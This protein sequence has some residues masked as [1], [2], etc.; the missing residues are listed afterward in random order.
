MSGA[1]GSRRRPVGISGELGEALTAP[2]AGEHVDE[3]VLGAE[4]VP[5]P[6]VSGRD[7][8]TVP[9]VVL[10]GSR[11]RRGRLTGLRWRRWRCRDVVFEGCD[12]SGV[13]VEGGA[14]ERVEFRDCRMSGVVLAG[15]KLTDVL[16]SGCK[17]DLANLR[18]VEGRR[19][20]FTDCALLE[21]DFHE[22]RLSGGRIEDSELGG[23]DFTGGSLPGLRLHGSGLRGLV[24]AEALRGAVIGPDQVLDVAT[25]LFDAAGIAVADRG[26]SA[27]T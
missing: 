5:E 3:V 2:V 16:F 27:A 18:M 4:H 26:Q 21:A 8:G 19:V 9:D 10:S 7:A 25:A 24:G 12:L 13:I 20:E 1:R 23:A 22:A 15:A 17:L 6:L 14:L 11:W